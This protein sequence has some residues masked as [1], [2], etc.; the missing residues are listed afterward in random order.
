[1]TTDPQDE[2]FDIINEQ[3]KV[4]GQATR[5]ECHADKSLIHRSISVG[6]FNDQGEILLQQRSL[7]KDMEPGFWDISCGGHVSASQTYQETATRELQEELGISVP[8]KLLKIHLTRMSHESEFSAVFRGYHNG[9]FTPHPQEI[10]SLQFFNPDELKN[11]N[12]TEQ[13]SINLKQV[14]HL[15]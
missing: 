12:L 5:R 11:I 7:T 3:D 4:I 15:L 8:I 14:F 9:P 13:V 1:M 2:L 10:S 6:I